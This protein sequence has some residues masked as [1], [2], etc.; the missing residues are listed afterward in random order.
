MY[1]LEYDTNGVV[2]KITPNAPFGLIGI[3][4]NELPIPIETMLERGTI[5]KIEEETKIYYKIKGE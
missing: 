5:D 2:E 3:Y 1:L 4:V